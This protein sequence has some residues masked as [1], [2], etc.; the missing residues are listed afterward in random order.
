MSST[1]EQLHTPTHRFLEGTGFRVF[2]ELGSAALHY[3]RCE[4]EGISHDQA[5]QQLAKKV[6]GNVI[7]FEWEY[8]RQLSFMG[9][10]IK[11][12]E[13]QGRLRWKGEYGDQLLVDTV[14]DSERLGAVNDAITELEEKLEKA[15]VGTVGGFNSPAGPSGMFPEPNKEIIHADNVTYLYEKTARGLRAYSMVTDADVKSVDQESKRIDFDPIYQ[16]SIQFL[17]NLGV[18]NPLLGQG[19]SPI[20]RAANISRS[21]FVLEPEEH[22]ADGLRG[23]AEKMKMAMGT[24]VAR[25]IRIPGKLDKVL[26]F[27]ELCQTIDRAEELFQVNHKTKE[28]LSRFQ[29]YFGLLMPDILSQ[30]QEQGVDLQSMLELPKE[31][32]LAQLAER[33]KY[34]LPGRELADQLCQTLLRIQASIYGGNESGELMAA[35]LGCNTADLT[36]GTKNLLSAL[37]IRSIFVLDRKDPNHPDY[38]IHCG[39]CGRE[40]KQVILHGESCPSCGEVRVC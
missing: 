19:N 9:N 31:Q 25:H 34:Q 21:V 29:E 30:L 2:D 12:V 18:T 3:A 16:Q 5:M 6:D 28:E 33:I 23:V 7:T 22:G 32:A 35:L 26:T 17:R 14:D 13:H 27:D 24:D 8:L 39:N 38:C 4:Q 15:P 37:G 40:I 36:I 1:T 10:P 20:E 11:E